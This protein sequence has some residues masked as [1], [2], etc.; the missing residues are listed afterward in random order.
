MYPCACIWLRST[1][2]TTLGTKRARLQ[3]HNPRVHHCPGARQVR[4]LPN[5]PAYLSSPKPSHQGGSVPIQ[6]RSQ[7]VSYPSYPRRMLLYYSTRQPVNPV[8]PRQ[9]DTLPST[10]IQ[11]NPTSPFQFRLSHL[12]PF[13]T[14]TT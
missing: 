12:F 7:Q 8:Q 9:P 2:D 4:Y 6:R 13:I 14:L 3:K 5:V 1:Y 10:P 11:K